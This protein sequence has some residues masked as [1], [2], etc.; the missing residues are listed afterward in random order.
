MFVL[1]LLCYFSYLH[2]FATFVSAFIFIVVA[3]VVGFAAATI[4]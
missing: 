3:I 2:L 1:F 4:I